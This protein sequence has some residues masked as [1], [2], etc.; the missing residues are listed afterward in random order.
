[1]IRAL[2]L[3][4]PFISEIFRNQSPE[5]TRTKW[6]VI[7]RTL[8]ISIF[9]ISILMNWWL[10]KRT[11]N[12]SMTVY[13][14]RPVVQEGQRCAVELDHEKRLNA[15]LLDIIGQTNNKKASVNQYNNYVAKLKPEDGLE[16]PP[17]AVPSV[18]AAPPTPPD[19]SVK[20]TVPQDSMKKGRYSKD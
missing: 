3:V 9:L 6:D 7:K 5:K 4:T 15:S 20:N 14:Q 18:A 17:V 10:L 11:F 12:L 1:M 19:N 13:N 2:D 16:E 8:G